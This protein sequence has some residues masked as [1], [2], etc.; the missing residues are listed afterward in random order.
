LT[1]TSGQLF[2][3]PLVNKECQAHLATPASLAKGAR[4]E[5]LAQRVLLVNC[6]P[7]SRF[8]P[9]AQ[10]HRSNMSPF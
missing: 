7:P 8:L 5:C 4:W 9:A 1:L 3:V 10:L 6:T 2:R